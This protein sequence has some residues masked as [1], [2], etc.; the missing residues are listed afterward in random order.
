MK[1]A[2]RDRRTH[3]YTRITLAI[4]NFSGAERVDLKTKFFK[5]IRSR[6]YLWN[7]APGVPLWNVLG[8]FGK[9]QHDDWT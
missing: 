4:C 2:P 1:C 9:R 3:I 8:L 7:H 5:Q 6:N